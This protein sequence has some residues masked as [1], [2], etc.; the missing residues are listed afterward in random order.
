[1]AEAPIADCRLPTAEI[2]RTTMADS[3]NLMLPY[4][5][6]AQ[7][8]KHV[9]VNESLRLLDA[10][11]RTRVVEQGLT[12]PPSTPA[13]GSVYIPASGATGAWD[14][15]DFNLAYYV[16]GAWR[17]IVPKVGW[18]IY[19]ID[20]DAYYKFEGDPT[21]W[22]EF[23]SGGGGGAAREANAT[24]RAATTANITIATALNDGDTLD[25]VT[26][27][28]GDRVLVKDQSA[29]EENGVYTVGAMPERHADFDAYDEHPGV[30][31]AVQ[32]GTANADT[33]WLCTSDIGGTLDTTAIVFDEF[34]GGAA[35]GGDPGLVPLAAVTVG[36]AVASV[37]LET[38]VGATY[39]K[40]IIDFDAQPVTD[41]VVLQMRMKVGGSYLDTDEYDFDR[42]YMGNAGGTDGFAGGAAAAAIG[43]YGGCGNQANESIGG[44]LEMLGA[45]RSDFKRGLFRN[46]GLNV[47]P[48]FYFQQGS[49]LLRSTG[50]VQGFRFFFSA[51]DIAP[52]SV[53]TAYGVRKP[54]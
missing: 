29:A 36:S 48:K 3:T 32:E 16:D 51:G 42:Q 39:E 12:A 11:V 44:A 53:F 6:A 28:A 49:F 8:Q 14:D 1:V 46:G 7:A 45:N 27:A 2:E 23:S 26:L 22:V 54:S 33:L 38:G 19:D 35:G 34:E 10:L 43:L 9:T 15:W 41:N 20:E 13:D 37:D 24:V 25:G 5:S 4:L 47:E 21:Y 18:L 17:K 40:Y 30:L 50:A 52:G 31:I